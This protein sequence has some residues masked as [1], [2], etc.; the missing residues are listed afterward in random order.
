MRAS[1]LLFKAIFLFPYQLG[2][3]FS[4]NYF[5]AILLWRCQAACNALANDVNW[6]SIEMA[7]KERG[8]KAPQSV[9][10]G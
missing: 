5:F 8:A 10:Q 2:K 3:I 9:S 1:A 7:Q 4:L 6:G